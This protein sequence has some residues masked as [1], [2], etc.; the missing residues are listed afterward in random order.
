MGQAGKDH[1]V[2]Q[3]EEKRPVSEIGGRITVIARSP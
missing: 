2:N 1:L 3:T